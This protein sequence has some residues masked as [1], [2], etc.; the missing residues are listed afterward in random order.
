MRISKIKKIIVLMGATSFINLTFIPPAEAQ[1]AVA[2]LRSIDANVRTILMEKLNQFPEYM[3]KLAEFLQAWMEEDKSEPTVTMQGN[4]TKLGKLLVD[5]MGAQD[6]LQTKLNTSLINND[7][8]N[9]ILL[10]QGMVPRTNLVTAKTMPYANDVLYSSLVQKPLY[11]KDPR[12]TDNNKIDFAMNYIKNASG[13]NLYHEL[14]NDSWKGRVDS[15][16]K[17]QS[18]FNTVM[19]AESFNSYVLSYQYALK[20]DFNTLQKD[21]IEQASDQAKWFAKV[22]SEN[23]GFVLRQILFY[24]SQSFVLL[25]QLVQTQK[26]MVTAQTITNSLLIASNSI[27]ESLMLSSAKGEQ[28]RV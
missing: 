23:I 10:N 20:D 25:S 15:Q 21:L 5:T 24:Q 16:I 26:Q 14:P 7:G 3:Q 13:M 6:D 9:V 12:S 1:D 19:A 4:F 17:Y 22:S 11:P 27:N 28:A 18:Y 8:N 2:Y